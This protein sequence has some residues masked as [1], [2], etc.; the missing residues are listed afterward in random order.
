[1]YISERTITLV[2]RIF[3]SVEITHS[4]SRVSEFKTCWLHSSWRHVCREEASKNK[5]YHI[6]NKLVDAEEEVLKGQHGLCL[7]NNIL[8]VHPLH[9]LCFVMVLT[10]SIQSI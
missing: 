9:V 3:K 6:L 10:T 2:L 7:E 4:E 8:F 1:M 5:F